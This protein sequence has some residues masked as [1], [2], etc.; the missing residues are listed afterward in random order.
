MCAGALMLG[1]ATLGAQPAPTPLSPQVTKTVPPVT[2]IAPAPSKQVPG[3][4]DLLFKAGPTFSEFGALWWTPFVKAG[5]SVLQRDGASDVRLLGGYVRPLLGAPSKGELV[6]GGNLASYAD[7][8]GSDWDVQAEYRHSSGLG[9]G[10]GRFE[11]RAG[12]PGATFVKGGWRGR[13]LGRVDV[14][15]HAQAQRQAERWSPGAYVALSDARHMLVAGHDGE[16]WRVTLGFVAPDTKRS[17]RPAAEVLY[18]DNGVGRLPGPTF[19]FANASL[20]FRGGFLAHASRL[21]RAMGPQ[22]LEFGNPLGFV[23]PSWNRR[24]ETWELGE[25]VDLR[26]VRTRAPNG[27]LTESYEALVF[28]GQVAGR[29]SGAWSA[30]FVGGAWDA[31]GGARTRRVLLGAAARAGRVVL[32][33]GLYLSLDGGGLQATLGAVRRF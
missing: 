3:K 1:A 11:R 33:G 31:A 15:A 12:A 9:V 10:A 4:T 8:G 19:L 25:M 32:A 18:V 29:R 27:R 22:G 28:P 17:W 26:A 7:G 24:L 5:A 6:L 20:G 23:T 13:A 2:K 14:I 30:P 21:G 16:Q